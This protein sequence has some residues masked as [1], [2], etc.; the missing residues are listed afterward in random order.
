MER[1]NNIR[2]DY[3]TVDV[4][5]V[6]RILW[7]KIWAV[8]LS[9]IVVAA[10]FFCYSAFFITPKYSSSI[11]LYVNNSS[12]SLGNTSV[13]ISNSEITAAQSLVK[14]YMVILN[15]RTTLE[16][17]INETGVNYTYD[18]I[19]K[20]ISSTQV[21]ETEV[22]RIT[23]TAENP[24]EAALIANGIAEVLPDRVSEI[25]DGSSVRVVDMAIVDEQK[26]SPNISQNTLIGLLIGIVAACLVIVIIA[27]LD[28]TIRDEEFILNNYDAPILSKIPNLL[29]KGDKEYGYYSYY[30]KRK[31][32]KMNY[33]VDES[34]DK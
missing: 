18:E 30:G 27:M 29:D 5:H 13:S 16:E 23:I 33:N 22:F 2:P 26:I 31:S 3:N 4:M 20:M 32:Y 17:L 34:G 24:E 6:L 28:D 14:T 10:V 11:M 15:N 19:Q 25:I 9:G 8:I 21:D 1:D 12:I 7:H